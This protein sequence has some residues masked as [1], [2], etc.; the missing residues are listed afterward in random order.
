MRGEEED[1]EEEEEE[2][3]VPKFPFHKDEDLTKAG[4]KEGYISC[5]VIQY[6]NTAGLDSSEEVSELGTWHCYGCVI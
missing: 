1:E 2:E 3:M 4:E 6:R 5:E